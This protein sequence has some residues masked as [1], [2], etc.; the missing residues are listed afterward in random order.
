MNCAQVGLLQSLDHPNIIKYHDS[1][2]DENSLVIIVEWA[3]AGDLKRQLRK[4]QERDTGFDERIIWKY[5]SQMADAIQHM[6]ERR[7][8]HRD[9]KPANIFLTL[10]GTV[11]VGDLGLSREL[12]ENTYQAHSKVGTPLYMSP[13]V[14]R[15][16]GYDFKSDVWSLGCLLYELAMLKSPFKSEGLNLYSLFQK[17][18]Q[19]EYSALPDK[20]SGELPTL[21]YAMISTNPED[22]PDIAD[23]CVQARDLRAKFND[24]YLKRKQQLL[25]D[26]DSAESSAPSRPPVEELSG[27][28][29]KKGTDRRV[30]DDAGGGEVRD[31][32]EGGGGRGS[33]D[34]GGSGERSTNIT[35][36]TDVDDDDSTHTE[37][38]CSNVK[39][40][41]RA[42]IRRDPPPQE[43]PRTLPHGPHDPPRGEHGGSRGIVAKP[44]ILRPK[45]SSPDRPPDHE[46]SFIPYTKPSQPTPTK[47]SPP[48]QLQQPVIQK[49]RKESPVGSAAP[50]FPHRAAQSSTSSKVSIP[51]TD[52]G[53]DMFFD[54]GAPVDEGGDSMTGEA[55]KNPPSSR[56]ASAGPALAIMDVVY[57]KLTVLG[58]PMYTQEGTG[59]CKITPVHFASDAASLFG[60]QAK[61]AFPSSQFGS[62]VEICLWL[63]G[64][65]NGSGSPPG[66]VDVDK[67]P[68][69]T[70][71]RQLL[72]FAQVMRRHGVAA[73]LC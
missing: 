54:D 73:T 31:E 1:F 62:F 9:L 29:D 5:F 20:Y 51:G 63:A 11:K 64:V 14:L 53:T 55:R 65:A 35:H 8:M 33:G 70:I 17:I 41:H 43:A 22:R 46:P 26:K 21:T 19:G 34:G 3:A 39:G 6:H 18:S 30:A 58:Y 36:R 16:D 48:T 66:P 61:A 25:E 45:R 69:A 23:I 27:L 10:D 24:E 38:T 49:R 47:G 40:T 7:I 12:S 50:S 52:T 60:R 37:D 4:A 28:V 72:R 57:A 13:E 56:L 71:A 2:I 44:P 68:P 59:R 15:G 67:D 32:E 42:R